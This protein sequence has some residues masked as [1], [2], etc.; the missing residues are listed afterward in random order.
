ME[1]HAVE[2]LNANAAGPDGIAA[3]PPSGTCSQ[4]RGHMAGASLDLLEP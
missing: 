3:P 1:R 2:D 4:R